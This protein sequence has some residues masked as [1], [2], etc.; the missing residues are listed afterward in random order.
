[1]ARAGHL[2]LPNLHGCDVKDFERFGFLDVIKGNGH[3]RSFWGDKSK[4]KQNIIST[5]KVDQ[6]ANTRKKVTSSMD[7]E[8]LGNIKKL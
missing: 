4:E 8:I 3:S 7:K 6:A 2:H 1:M 5:Y